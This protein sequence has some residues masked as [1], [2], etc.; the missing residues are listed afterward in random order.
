MQLPG[1]LLYEIAGK[2]GKGHR[3][4]LAAGEIMQVGAGVPGKLQ[5]GTLRAPGEKG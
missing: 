5:G 4:E 3:R 1:H 2:A